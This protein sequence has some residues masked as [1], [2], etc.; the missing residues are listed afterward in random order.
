[1]IFYK[2]ML[3]EFY[4][5]K[6]ANSFHIVSNLTGWHFSCNHRLNKEILQKTG[7]LSDKE[8]QSLAQLKLLLEKYNFG[9]KKGFIGNPFLTNPDEKTWQAVS[10]YLETNEIKQLKEI[11]TVF[12]NRFNKLWPETK[13]S[14]EVWKSEL[15][16][17]AKSKT[18]KAIEKDLVTFLATRSQENCLI[19][20]Y[21]LAS[22]TNSCSGQRNIGENALTLECSGVS[23][24][25]HKNI[26]CSCLWHESIHAALE[27]Y[28]LNP[29]IWSFLK[30][31]DQSILKS[32]PVVKTVQEPSI[33]FR[34]G[35]I[36][37]LFSQGILAKKYFDIRVKI[38]EKEKL[39][40]LSSEKAQSLAFWCVYC[41]ENLKDLTENYLEQKKKID[42]EYLESVFELYKSY[43]KSFK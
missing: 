9:S 33:I 43:A 8:K 42:K 41:A 17:E 25:K 5:S 29:L 24:E 20:V 12:Q 19:K 23:Q 34:E 30:E 28:Y 32:H 27:K 31:K 15:S 16:Y 36:S 6:N 2:Q 38:P 21:L 18:F 1:M 7:G 13:K 37:T 39:K 40:N 14:L 10:E 26:V 4:F 11:F 22:A 3:F 35:V